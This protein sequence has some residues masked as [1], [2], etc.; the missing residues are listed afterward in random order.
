VD[1]TKVPGGNFM[2][3]LTGERTPTDRDRASD[4]HAGRIALEIPIQ[5][6]SGSD[7]WNGVT[8]N[9]CAGG[10]FVATLRLLAVGERVAVR[11]RL[12]GDVEPVDALAEV[13][14]SRPFQELDDR[15]AGLGLRFVDTPL[16]AVRI[17]WSAGQPPGPRADR[18]RR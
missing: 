18:G 12:P 17:T 1:A 13:R 15:P 6:R 14:W 9:L 2:S 5:I 10:V 16:R 8:K 4:G 7:W 3:V 11:L